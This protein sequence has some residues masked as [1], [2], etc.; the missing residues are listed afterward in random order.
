MKIIFLYVHDEKG[1]G[2]LSR[3]I[4]V[5]DIL[6]IKFSPIFLI[7]GTLK[8]P[9]W[10][11]YFKL[12]YATEFE[13]YDDGGI[14]DHKNLQIRKK[15]IKELLDRYDNY[16]ILIDY[17][18][19]GRIIFCDEFDMM[20]HETHKKWGK[21]YSVMRD[22]FRWIQK[23]DEKYY[24]EAI[25]ILG[26]KNIVIYNWECWTKDFQR[27]IYSHLKEYW[28]IHAAENILV[29]FYLHAWRIDNILVFWDEDFYDIR[30]EFF[31]TKKEKEKFLFMW[32]LMWNKSRDQKPV[33]NKEPYILISFGWNIFDMKV[34]L[35]LLFLCSQVENISFK[36]VLGA[37]I[38]KN[39][40][41]DLK[42]KFSSYIHMEF[43][44]FTNDFQTLFKSATI[45]IGAW[46]YGTIMDVVQHQKPSFLFVNKNN[47]VQVN[48][49]EQDMRIWLIWNMSFVKRVQKVD[50]FF[51]KELIEIYFNS[52]HLKVLDNLPLSVNNDRVLQ[53]F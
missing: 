42:A 29:Q 53:I 30:D 43:I 28:Y 11:E 32:Y 21:I 18:P 9:V 15:F 25:N 3:M 2:H 31:L 48:E 12:P 22:I 50:K 4:K 33:V 10:R 17:F 36:I 47:V 13:N 19:F 46:W 52:K 7:G 49:S 27:K 38:E 44:D 6:S 14:Q 40:A 45:F 8:P 20:I 24:K 37:M 41:Q 26:E 34:F 16:D 5:Y 23:R 51:L 35:E 39:V 1:Y